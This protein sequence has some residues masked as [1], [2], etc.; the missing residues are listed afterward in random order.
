ML[1]FKGKIRIE[2]WNQ[3]IKIMKIES[4][5]DN[6]DEFINNLINEAIKIDKNLKIAAY[7]VKVHSFMEM[8]IVFGKIDEEMVKKD[9]IV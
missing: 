5:S 1:N 7:P 2:L 9:S 4:W 8:V 3:K 6:N